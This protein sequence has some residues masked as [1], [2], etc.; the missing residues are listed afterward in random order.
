MMKE[1]LSKYLKKKIVLDTSS[2]WIYI[3]ILEKVFESCVLLSD[4]DVHDNTDS[5]ST[6]ECYVLDSKKT[7]IKFNRHKA[8]IS[9]DYIV[10]F[11]ALDDVKFF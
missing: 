5:N 1:V 9:L 10:S 11:S 3:G 4:V 6:K 8:Y 2:T 7:G